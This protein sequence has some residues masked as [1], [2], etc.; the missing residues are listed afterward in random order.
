MGRYFSS[1]KSG[2]A[3]KSEL[4]RVFLVFDAGFF[5]LSISLFAHFAT[6]GGELLKEYFL[7][8]HGTLC[9]DM[10]HDL[11]A[12]LQVEL[13]PVFDV[14][15]QDVALG[16]LNAG[17][18]DKLKVI[19]REEGCE[20]CVRACGLRLNLFERCG[21]ESFLPCCTL[22]KNILNR[23]LSWDGL[24][25]LFKSCLVLFLNRGLFL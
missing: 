13:G 18:A 3:L 23:L 4:K 24:K 2:D 16:Q 21:E 8:M 1:F 12:L 6:D 17:S 25:S 15:L 5:I 22:G 7:G 20:T 11:S 10:A 14:H 19:F 9:V